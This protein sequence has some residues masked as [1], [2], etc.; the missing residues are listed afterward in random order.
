MIHNIDIMAYLYVFSDTY[1]ELRNAS[2]IDATKT[3]ITR[4]D[5]ERMAAQFDSLSKQAT[6]LSEFFNSIEDIQ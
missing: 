4:K 3:Y 2:M 6:A 5:A 1:N